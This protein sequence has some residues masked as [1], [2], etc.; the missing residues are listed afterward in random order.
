MTK[1]S[2]LLSLLLV[3]VLTLS[4]FAACSP[5]DQKNGEKTDTPKDAEM[6]YI[7]PE[8]LKKDLDSD[9]YLILD[10]RKDADFKEGHIPGANSADLDVVVSDNDIEKGNEVVKKAI[11]GNDKI[12]VLVCYSGKRYAQAGTNALQA[13]E[14]DL[15]QVYTL[16]GG[17]KAW[18]EKYPDD[19]TK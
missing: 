2:K 14:Q 19:I 10:L 11:D 12:I 8:D 17:M 4:V 5:A 18:T 9:K 13:L 6:Q 1:Q 3:F 15:S 16:E 7:S